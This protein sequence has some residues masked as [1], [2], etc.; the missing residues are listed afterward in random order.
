MTRKLVLGSIVVLLTLFFFRDCLS[1]SSNSTRL[2]KEGRTPPEIEVGL[3]WYPIPRQFVVKGPAFV[4]SY[5]RDPHF[6]SAQSADHQSSME[7]I[8][9]QVLRINPAFKRELQREVISL[10][11]GGVV[12]HYELDDHPIHLDTKRKPMVLALSEETVLL[13]MRAY[14]WSGSVEDGSDFELLFIWLDK[15]GAARVV[16]KSDEVEW[17]KAFDFVRQ[18]RDV[19]LWESHCPSI[20]RFDWP[21]YKELT[22]VQCY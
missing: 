17:R 14:T 20:Y 10:E 21:L 1:I 9:V 19:L 2:T 22:N 11:R 13:F 15:T 12:V 7:R 3:Q 18:R 16:R 4:G 5:F 6:S 8:K